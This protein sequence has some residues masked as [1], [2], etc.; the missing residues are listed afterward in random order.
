M[1]KFVATTPLPVQCQCVCVCTCVDKSKGET[2]EN[3]IWKLFWTFI[4][5]FFFLSKR[6]KEEINLPFPFIWLSSAIVG[7]APR[8]HPVPIRPF[9]AIGLG[10][11]GTPDNT[12]FRVGKYV[13]VVIFYTFIVPCRNISSLLCKMALL[14]HRSFPLGQARDLPRMVPSFVERRK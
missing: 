14:A 13:Y 11:G 3:S 8:V 5:F 9:L 12:S 1:L 2:P 4:S 7:L 10:L 6:E